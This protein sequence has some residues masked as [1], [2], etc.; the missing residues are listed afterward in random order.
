MLAEQ[1]QLAVGGE[2]DWTDIFCGAGGSS[3]GVEAV[4]GMRV[5]QALNHW[6][7]AVEAHNANFPDADHDLHD[8]EEVPATRF[9]RTRCLWASPDCTHH[10]YCR[11]PR[12]DDPEATRSRA[13]FRDIIRFTAHHRYDAVVVENVIEARL[14]CDRRGHKKKCSCGSSFDAWHREMRALGYDSKVVYFNSQFAL[15]TPQ[16]RDRMYVVFWRHGLRAPNLDFRPVSWCSHCIQVVEGI[17]TWKPATKGSVRSQRGMFEWGRYGS[18]YLYTCPKCAKPVAPAVVGA[19]SIIDWTLP[20]LAIGDRAKPLAVKTRERIKAGL[21][22]LS[23]LDPVTVQ[24][25]GNLYERRPGVRVWSLADP[26]RTVVGTSQMAMVAPA[27]GQEARARDASEPMHTVVGSDR[28]AL[29]VRYGGQGGNGRGD[30]ETMQTITAHDREIGLVIP[31][32]EHAVGAALDEP[33]GTVTTAPAQH[34]LVLQKPSNGTG[35]GDEEPM[36]A[37]AASSGE[38]MLV[39]VA[40]SKSRR[41]TLIDEPAKTIAGHGELALVTLRNH[42]VVRTAAEPTPTVT[43]G[44]N[45]HGVLVYNG[46]PGFVRSLDDAGGTV[47]G[48]DKQSLLVPYYGTGVA[49]DASEP[50]GAVTSKDRHALVVTDD[51]IDACL[52]R[53]LQWPELLRAQQMHLHPDGRPYELTAQ[54]LDKRGRMRELS[55]EQRVRMIGNAVSSPVATM[56]GAA[57]AEILAEAA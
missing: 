1:L 5:T 39:Q 43:G 38:H 56:L 44:G 4:P 17:Q 3:L 7:L 35:R 6:D 18:Q 57:I 32:R 2:V 42:D 19:R 30:G 36:P 52:F 46:V 8:V 21:E 34:A 47:T 31:N 23:A 48:R 28:L 51:D 13:T 37:I 15:P 41:E 55:N 33:A 29:I 26:L 27:G 45:H 11:G 10:A 16:S 22:R 20:A 25:G 49:H 40:R 9:R 54:R 12:A 14:W 53:M 24:V 50:V